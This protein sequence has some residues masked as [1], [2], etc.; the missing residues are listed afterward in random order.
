MEIGAHDSSWGSVLNLVLDLVEQMTWGY[1]TVAVAGDTALSAIPDG[2][3]GTTRNSVLKFTGSPAGQANITIPTGLVRL[4][5]VWNATTQSLVFKYA[6][7][8]TVTVASGKKDHL[9]ADGTDIVRL[10]PAV[11]NDDWAGTDLAIA[12]GGTGA[13]DAATARS[14][15]GLGA[16]AVLSS[17]NDSNWSGTDLAIANGGTGASDASTARTNLGLGTMAVVNSPAP[18]ANGGTGATTAADAR[19]ALGLG[20]L[21]LLNSVNNDNWSGTDLAV[22]NGGTG[23]SDA[24]TARA[25]LGIG[26]MATR[27]VFIDTASPS[28]GSDGDVWLKYTP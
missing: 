26:S 1:T 28:G 11:N 19:T 24:S 22:A 21:A 4:F 6:S 20:S 2:A 16:L 27:A 7:G 25:N 10:A 15:L 9:L 23:A 18:I 17:V 8:A 3:T 13:S 12:N 14:N 5:K